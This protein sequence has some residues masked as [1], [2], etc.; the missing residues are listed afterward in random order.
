MRR[1]RRASDPGSPVHAD[2]LAEELGGR[3]L[4]AASVARY[5]E[6][7]QIDAE[8]KDCSRGDVS[9]RYRC[10]HPECVRQ[11]RAQADNSTDFGDH[12]RTLRCDLN[13]ADDPR[14]SRLITKIVAAVA[15][16]TSDG[17]KY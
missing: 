7:D 17:N 1:I 2:R 6:K 3:A 8:A 13:G 9:R 10:N 5:K 4:I 11:R 14:P 12:C 15:G 16:E